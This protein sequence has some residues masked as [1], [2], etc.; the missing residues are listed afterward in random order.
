MNGRRA[1]RVRGGAARGGHGAGRN[2]ARPDGSGPGRDA[3]GADGSRAQ[4]AAERTAA[5]VGHLS[6]GPAA[7][8]GTWFGAGDDAGQQRPVGGV[9]EPG[10]EDPDDLDAV[11]PL[12][13]HVGAVGAADVDQDPAAALDPQFRMVPGHPVVGDRDV[14]LGVPPDPVCRTG[15]QD[16]LDPLVT[17]DER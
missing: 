13:G 9:A 6:G 15:G 10:Q 8:R 7:R 2:A 3:A 12:I 16:A 1:T 17:H 5:Q 11:H 14:A 4:A